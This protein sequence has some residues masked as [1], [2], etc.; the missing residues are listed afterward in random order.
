MLPFL[1][2]SREDSVPLLE[3]EDGRFQMLE[4]GPV[5]KFAPG[6]QYLLVDRALARY[7]RSLKVQEVT[8]A[9]AVIVNRTTGQEIRSHTKVFV[10]RSFHADE[11]KTLSLEGLQL[12]TMNYEHFFASPSLKYALEANAFGY[13]EFSEGLGAFAGAA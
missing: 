11:I 13:L 1:I 12:L 6:Y 7:M 5:A 9:P 2:T 8:F 10:S 3:L 4:Q